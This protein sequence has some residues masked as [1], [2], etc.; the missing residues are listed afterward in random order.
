MS[1]PMVLLCSAMHCSSS[2]MRVFSADKF[3]GAFEA[4]M[5]EDGWWLMKSVCE[6][7]CSKRWHVTCA[8]WYLTWLNHQKILSYKTPYSI[9]KCLESWEIFLWQLRWPTIQIT[10][11]AFSYI[12]ALRLSQT[13][14]ICFCRR[15]WII[16]LRALILEATFCALSWVRR[17][18]DIA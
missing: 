2:A 14:S 1:T 16:E 18:L 15:Q 10:D 7:I 9:R 5:V 8:T 13:N 11:T 4:G 17:I 3:F 6:G 12:D